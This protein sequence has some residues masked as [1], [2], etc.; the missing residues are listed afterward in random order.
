MVGLEVG[1]H[2][3]SSGDHIKHPHTWGGGVAMQVETFG[4]AGSKTLIGAF[5]VLLGQRASDAA[6]KKEQQP[7]E[8]FP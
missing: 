4:I 6:D 7:C 2:H 1:N 5:T 8:K 3:C